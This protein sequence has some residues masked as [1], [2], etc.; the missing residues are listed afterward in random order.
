MGFSPVIQLYL[1]EESQIA[2]KFLVDGGFLCYIAP[3]LWDK[4]KQALCIAIIFIFY[5]FV[6]FTTIF[7][8][9]FSVFIFLVSLQGSSVNCFVR[10]VLQWYIIPGLY[11]CCSIMFALVQTKTEH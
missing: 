9:W 11:M 10:Y 6:A 4:I 8:H 3:L 5:I 1:I 2:H 7:A